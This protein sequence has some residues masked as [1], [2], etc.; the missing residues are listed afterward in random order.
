MIKRNNLQEMSNENNYYKEYG[1]FHATY[2]SH[3]LTS[4]KDHISNHEL[5][6]ESLGFQYWLNSK[7]SKVYNDDM[8]YAL[9]HIGEAMIHVLFSSNILSLYA[10]FMTAKQGLLQ[11]TIPNLRSVFESIPKMYY[12]SFFPEEWDKIAIKEEI[13]GKTKEE[14]QKY[15]ESDSRLIIRIK[16]TIKIDAEF[17]KEIKNKY[18][19]KWFLKQIYSE[20]QIKK[21]NST[22]GSFSKSS[23]GGITR[24][25]DD[26]YNKKNINDVL[27]L[28]EFL[29]FFNIVSYLNGNGSTMA[30]GK[31]P[32][33]EVKSFTEK[34]RSKLVNNDGKMFSL[35]PDKPEIAKKIFLSPP[36]P[37]WHDD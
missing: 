28:I 2:F 9:E 3:E 12:I 22:Y 18:Y 7:I 13:T 25:K 27:E 23:H 20:M 10:G 31:F 34:I 30:E 4:I 17:I 1:N 8:N 26:G 37:P 5:I 29:S 11:Q 16:N 19:F 32:I 36:G 35:F 24:G 33:S 6:E 15:L 14:I 21:L